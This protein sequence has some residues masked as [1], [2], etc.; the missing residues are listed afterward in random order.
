MTAG[1]QPSVDIAWSLTSFEGACREQ[2]RRWAELPLARILM[3]IEE[4]QEVARQTGAPVPT[5]PGKATGSA[6]V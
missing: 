3:A 6:P 5:G 1:D 2:M 4:M